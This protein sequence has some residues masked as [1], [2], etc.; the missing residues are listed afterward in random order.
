MRRTSQ[1]WS[2]FLQSCFAVV[3]SVTGYQ[4]TW[5]AGLVG[6]RRYQK[7]ARLRSAVETSWV[8]LLPR[9][10]CARCPPAGP[11]PLW[12]PGEIGIELAQLRALLLAAP[13]SAGCPPTPPLCCRGHRGA[14][15]LLAATSAKLLCTDQRASVGVSL[16]P[17]V[18]GYR[19]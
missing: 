11:G 12:A 15:R 18:A 16:L 10:V 17:G 9:A 6:K 5:I 13:F 4:T 3:L 1:S 19:H 2:S 8:V 7:S 14:L